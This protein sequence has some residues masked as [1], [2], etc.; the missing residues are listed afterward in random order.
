MKRDTSIIWLA[1][2][3]DADGCIRLSKG[4]KNK[5]GQYSLVPQIT[6]HNTCFRTMEHIVD[7]LETDFQIFFKKRNS[8]KHSEM[9]NINIMGIK[10]IYPFLVRILP[11]L[12]TK[13]MEGELLKKFMDK[14]LSGTHNRPYDNEEYKIYFA[15]KHIKK[16]R[17]LRD[18]T[19]NIEKILNEDIVRT[20]A[21]S[22]EAAETS[23]RLT[24]E[25]KKEWA[26]NLV[27]KY[28]WGLKSNNADRK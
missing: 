10:R 28:R 8:D 27:S 7:I 1:G 5:K 26:R 15:L 20:N 25:E 21:K 4:W 23:A 16:I 19:S 22:L 12:V 17:N 6:V 14:R 11:Y 2:F 9:V 18:Y 24:E 3:I 13:K